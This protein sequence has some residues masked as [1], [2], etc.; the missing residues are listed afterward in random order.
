MTDHVCADFAKVLG[1]PRNRIVWDRQDE[2]IA[3]RN[4]CIDGREG[5]Q[6]FGHDTRWTGNESDDPVSDPLR[7]QR[8][9]TPR[10]SRAEYH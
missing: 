4:G 1:D 3:G 2:Q 5:R 6:R 10:T 8:Q 7:G 9:G